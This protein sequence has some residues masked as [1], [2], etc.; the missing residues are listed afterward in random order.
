MK[1]PDEYW[2][3]AQH[4]HAAA[5]MTHDLC[6]QHQLDVLARSYTIL[7]ESTAAL[8]RASKDGVEGSGN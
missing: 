8:N 2:E 7:A 5:R 1:T 6:S 4:Y 3:R